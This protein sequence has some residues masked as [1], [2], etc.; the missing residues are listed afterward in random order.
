MYNVQEFDTNKQLIHITKIT[1]SCINRFI[2]LV[3][4][5]SNCPTQQAAQLCVTQR[6]F[7]QQFHLTRK[8]DL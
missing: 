4:C 8:T 7:T 6:C 1:L 2:K 3:V 5:F